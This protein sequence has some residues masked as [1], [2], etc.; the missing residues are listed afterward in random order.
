MTKIGICAPYGWEESAHLACRLGLLARQSNVQVSYRA[1]QS[2]RKGM[3]SYW[4]QRVIGTKCRESLA[5]WAKHRSHIIWFLPDQA[6]MSQTRHAGCQNIWVPLLR[7]YQV[8]ELIDSSQYCDVIACPDTSCYQ[9]LQQIVSSKKLVHLP[10]DMGGRLSEPAKGL[11]QSSR[12]SLFVTLDGGGV[13]AY[14]DLLVSV[15]PMWLDQQQRLHVTVDYPRQWQSAAG[16]LL[17]RLRSKH[18]DRLRLVRRA[19]T[20]ER[21]N[22]YASHDWTLCLTANCSSGWDGLE[23]LSHGRPVVAIERPPYIEYI[24]TGHNGL[25]LPGSQST[26]ING[27]YDVRPTVLYEALSR[28]FSD[29][30]LLDKIQDRTWHD[31]VNRWEYFVRC[32]RTIWNS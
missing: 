1:R 19:S 2:Y 5:S 4:D 9:Y 16:Q 26:D 27:C 8:K 15:L 28:V 10:W 6:G 3:N 32:W 22:I 18:I 13:A 12:P 7:R 14:G 21:R 20:T 11:L 30:Q 17:H 23:S 31:L 29:T 25:L 24:V